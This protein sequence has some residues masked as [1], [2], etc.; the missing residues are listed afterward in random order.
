MTKRLLLPLSMTLLLSCA[1]PYAVATP[2]SPCIIPAWPTWTVDLTQPLGKDEYVA[3]AAY[4][5]AA[6]EY[7]LAVRKCPYAKEEKHD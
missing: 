2:V 7:K 3:I 6:A 5:T 4:F 1:R